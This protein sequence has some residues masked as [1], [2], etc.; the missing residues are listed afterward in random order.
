MTKATGYLIVT[1]SQDGDQ[2]TEEEEIASQL[3]GRKPGPNL[4]VLL[5][6]QHFTQPP[7]FRRLP[8][9]TPEENGI[10]RLT[11]AHTAHCSSGVM[12]AAKVN[13]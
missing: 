11:Y 6:K 10:G 12:S 5:Q 4:R 1:R 13:A 3:S 2:S 9:R 8:G 7:C